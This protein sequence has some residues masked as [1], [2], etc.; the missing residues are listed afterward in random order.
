MVIFVPWIREEDC[1][2]YGICVEKCPVGAIDMQDNIAR[3][4]RK[5]ITEP[6]IP[7]SG[8]VQIIFRAGPTFGIEPMPVF[9]YR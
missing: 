7:F 6:S 2:G 9:R 5:S 3:M 1:I 8:H 4:D